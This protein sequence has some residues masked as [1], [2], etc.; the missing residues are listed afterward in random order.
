MFQY[1]QLPHI[2]NFVGGQVQGV[3]LGQRLDTLEVLQ[4]VVA[5]VQDG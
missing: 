1:F 5:D 3:E 2:I 4:F